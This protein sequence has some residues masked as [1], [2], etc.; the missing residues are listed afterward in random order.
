MLAVLLIYLLAA[1]NALGGF[2]LCMGTDGHIALK[3]AFHERRHHSPHG[4]QEGVYQLSQDTD[5]HAEGPHCKPCIDIPISMGLTG[6]QLPPDQ[7][8][9][10]SQALIVFL[11]S[12]AISDNILTPMTAPPRFHSI[13]PHSEFLRTVILLV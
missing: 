8:K 12:W 4:H 3:P 13:T 6:D 1:G 5:T 10:N 7:A 2:V 11:G 9:L